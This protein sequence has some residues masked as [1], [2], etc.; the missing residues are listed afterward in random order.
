MK[1]D[2]L[3]LDRFSERGEAQFD[4]DYR[5]AMEDLVLANLSAHFSGAS[6]Q[7]GIA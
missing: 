2:I 5:R 7:T 6:L 1:P 4:A 3:L